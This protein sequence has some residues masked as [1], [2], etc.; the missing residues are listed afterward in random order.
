[1]EQ[2]AQK[3]KLALEQIHARLDEVQKLA[4]HIAQRQREKDEHQTTVEIARKD[5]DRIDRKLT[6]LK[7]DIANQQLLQ[8]NEKETIR[9]A[10]E[11]VSPLLL[12]D[13]WQT[14]W[15]AS[16]TAFIERLQKSAG[17]YRMAQE[18]QTELKSAIALV[19]QELDNISAAREI[20]CEA[21]PEWRDLPA[22]EKQETKNLAA[23]WNALVSD[24]GGLKQKHR[25]RPQ[26]HR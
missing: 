18:K 10:F 5:F 8:E 25:V 20:V 3:N 12:W 11:R 4:N 7:N 9:T 14:E 2:L 26:E 24:A 13:G 23:A 19:T 16:P 6:T 21:F 22:E 1:M 17:Y 15:D